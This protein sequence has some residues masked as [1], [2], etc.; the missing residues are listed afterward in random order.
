MFSKSN[1]AAAFVPLKSVNARKLSFVQSLTKKVEGQ[2]AYFWLI[3]NLDPADARNQLDVPRQVAWR[4]IESVYRQAKEF[5]F[6]YAEI[7]Y[8]DSEDP[9]LTS[10]G[11]ANRA[12][13]VL[14]G[15]LCA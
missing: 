15:L 4:A 3:E 7:A 5:G 14:G 10:H 12:E 2:F 1:E 9:F 11:V 13:S 6:D 8:M